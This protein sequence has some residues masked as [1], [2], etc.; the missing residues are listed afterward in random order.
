MHYAPM[1]SRTSEIYAHVAHVV[2][3]NRRGYRGAG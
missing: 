3:A 2:V 1:A